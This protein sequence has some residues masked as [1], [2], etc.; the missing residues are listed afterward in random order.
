MWPY[1]VEMNAIIVFVFSLTL[2]QIYEVTSESFDG[3]SQIG[4]DGGRS[5]IAPEFVAPEISDINLGNLELKE[6]PKL[7]EF[8]YHGDD[9]IY[10][11]H[12]ND[13]LSVSYHNY[14]INVSIFML[15]ALRIIIL[16]FI[17]IDD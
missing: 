8:N 9:G 10:D 11:K 1:Y 14:H 7:S 5:F 16:V 13:I 4:R 2:V 3:R 17:V 6:V 12:S 15:Y